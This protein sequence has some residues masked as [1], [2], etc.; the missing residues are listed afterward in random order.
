M[1]PRI[2]V[3]YFDPPKSRTWTRL[4]RVLTRSVERHCHGWDL[5]MQEIATLP[6]SS[7]LG[8]QGNVANTHKL[9]AWA[10]AVQS[11]AD[12]DRLLLLDADTLIRRPIDDVWESAFDL[13]YT[14]K[15]KGARFPFN[16]GVV[17]LRVSPQVRAFVGRWRAENRRM[18]DDPIHHQVWRPAFGGIN[19]AALGMLL[20]LGGHGLEVHRLPCLEW[21]CE[22]ES[23]DSFDPERTRI[24][25]YK[26][27]LQRVV[28][29]QP[30]TESVPWVLVQEWRAMEEDPRIAG[31]VN[32]MQ[33]TEADIETPERPQADGDQPPLMTRVGR[34][35]QQQKG[36]VN[37]GPGTSA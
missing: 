6:L 17:F 32:N 26:S 25:H 5:D 22:D 4:A 13:A 16:G 20:K 21:N 36:G 9:D 18:L 35:R 31:R 19:Q 7:P 2:V 14:V 28:L 1:R 15:K 8:V 37:D 24:V 33:V 10:D 27:A 3:R 23:W 34:R 11:S 12:G 30:A 29:R